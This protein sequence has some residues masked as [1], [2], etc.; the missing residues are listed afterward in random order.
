M[1]ASGHVPTFSTTGNNVW[2]VLV[3]RHSGLNVG[4][5]AVNGP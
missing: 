3:N 5:A 2:N 4:N 1:T